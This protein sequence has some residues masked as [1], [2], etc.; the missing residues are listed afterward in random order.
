MAEVVV[1]K[2][3]TVELDPVKTEVHSM[4]D[5]PGQ[6]IPGSA[7]HYRQRDSTLGDDGRC[8]VG[9]IY[10][11]QQQQQGFAQPLGRDVLHQQL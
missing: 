4:V 6:T 3:A 5:H 10:Q 9:E 1:G 11:R 7:Q 2:T 8:T